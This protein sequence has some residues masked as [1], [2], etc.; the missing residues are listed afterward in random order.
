MAVSEFEHKLWER[1][2]RVWVEA[3]RPPPEIRSEV[4]LDFRIEGQSIEIFEIRAAWRRPGEKIESSVAKTTYVKSRE[5]WK[6]YWKRA[7][8]RWHRYDP[9][10]EMGSLQ[11]VLALVGE[12][13]YGA[14]WG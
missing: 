13:A 5:T 11:E 8:G 7:D 14:F 2:V 9:A 4:D 6:V 12:D 10:G 1:T 3:R